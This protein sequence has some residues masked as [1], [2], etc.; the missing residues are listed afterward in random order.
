[1][2]FTRMVLPD[3]LHEWKGK[4]PLFGM[5]DKASMLVQ[6]GFNKWLSLPFHFIPLADMHKVHCEINAVLK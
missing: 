1:M 6:F 2:S 3:I 4:S 5:D